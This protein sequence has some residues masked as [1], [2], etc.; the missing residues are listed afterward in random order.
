MSV[1]RVASRYAKSLLDLAVERNETEKVLADMQYFKEA[2][3]SKDLLNMVKSPIINTSKKGEIIDTLFKDK[4]DNT[5]MSFIQI[6]LRKGR[7]MFLPDVIKEFILQHKL[8]QK[9]S[10]AKLTV[11]SDISDAQLEEIK[12]KLL[13]SNITMDKLDL[14]VVVDPSIIGGFIVEIGDKLYDASVRHKL[15][16]LKKEFSGNDYVATI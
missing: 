4:F 14:D 8:M 3:K 15:G 1:K 5:T 7:E 11:A 2:L 16:K 13:D 10:Q 12:S 9:M 6:V